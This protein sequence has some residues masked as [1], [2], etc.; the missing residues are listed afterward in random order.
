MKQQ[1][2]SKLLRCGLHQCVWE[3]G[4]TRPCGLRWS[5]TTYVVKVVSSEDVIVRPRPSF[6]IDIH[7]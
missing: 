6:D 5:G 2:K 3:R 7:W 4:L 1:F